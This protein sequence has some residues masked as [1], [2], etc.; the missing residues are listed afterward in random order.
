MSDLEEGPDTDERTGRVVQPWL[1]R[2]SV[3]PPQPIV[4]Y[5]GNLVGLLEPERAAEAAGLHPKVLRGLPPD[6]RH[7]LA[8]M[9]S[10][11]GQAALT[12]TTWSAL[13]STWLDVEKLEAGPPHT[14]S[15][16][17]PLP[18][19]GCTVDF[20]LERWLEQADADDGSVILRQRAEPVVSQVVA[21]LEA[22]NGVL[23]GLTVVSEVTLHTSPATLVPRS[24]ELRRHMEA[25][26]PSGTSHRTAESRTWH[27]QPR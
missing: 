17:G 25:R 11:R 18:V 4:D 12:E 7:L 13:V 24:L 10:A 9:A 23:H 5:D 20:L 6:A 14:S 26:V 1:D 27:F 15:V 19:A 2:L 21:A 8:S 22:R 16:R 3:H